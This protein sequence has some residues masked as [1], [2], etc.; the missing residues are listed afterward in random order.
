M[1]CK[2]PAIWRAE[3]VLPAVM[4]W[5]A[6]QGSGVTTLSTTQVAGYLLLDF[7]NF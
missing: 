3:I 4:L 2:K 5:A 7:L 1:E 6:R